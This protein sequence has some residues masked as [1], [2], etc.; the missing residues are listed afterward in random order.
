MINAKHPNYRIPT[1]WSL[2][3]LAAIIWRII[4]L[5]SGAV[6]F[7][8]DE[9]IVGLM[10][11]HI[12]AGHAL[13]TFFY[14]QPYMGSLDPLLV[15]LAF[16]LLGESV[17]SIR[18]VQSILY[19][20]TIITTMLLTHRITRNDRIAAVTGFLMALPPTLVSLYTTI[21]LG[22][23]GELLII[24]NLL[25]LV[26]Y[27]IGAGRGKWWHWLIVGCLAGL[28]WWTHNLIVVYALPVGLSIIL[29]RKVSWQGALLALIA[30]FVCSAPWWIYNVNHDWQSV[31]FLL[32]GFQNITT[33]QSISVTDRLIGFLLLGIPAVLGLRYPWT[34]SVWTGMFG[35]FIVLVYQLTLMRSLKYPHTKLL[36]LMLGSVAIIFVL[37]SFGVDATGRYL[38]PMVTALAILGAI[39]AL[40]LSRSASLIVIS[41]FIGTNVIGTALALRSVPPGLTPQFD[42]ATDFTNTYDDQV[43]AFLQENGGKYGYA[44]YW[45][46]YRLAFLSKETIILSPQLPYK[47]TMVYTATDRYPA[48]TSLVEEAERPVF[49]TAN[50][51]QLDKIIKEKLSVAGIAFQ[52]QHIGPY[53]VFYAMSQRISPAALG[54]QNLP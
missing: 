43:I 9:A 39:G 13:P 40:T 34:T 25:L 8:S 20:L 12:I 21:S 14:G 32:G 16:R 6:S 15:S 46:S 48:Y 22:G 38:L 42:A 51:P 23:Y 3:L 50:L 54:L 36:W 1:S 52:E 33:G 7:H 17:L 24:G 27:E 11:R 29:Y 37:S 41:L 28:G 49:V 44:T 2:V 10:A 26:G 30:F 5:A 18:I 35:I 31:R 53:S 47:A 45:V 4:I 19:L